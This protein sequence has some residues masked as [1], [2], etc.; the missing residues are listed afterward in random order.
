MMNYINLCCTYLKEII[1]AKT[2]ISSNISDNA[3]QKENKMSD[4]S[5]IG[6]TKSSSQMRAGNQNVL[7]KNMLALKGLRYS[8]D[9][10]LKIANL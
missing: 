10:Y 5:D 8:L 7:F 2:M 1:F 6:K 4:I 3:R 9:L